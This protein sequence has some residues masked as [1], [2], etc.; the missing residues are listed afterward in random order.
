MYYENNWSWH[1][2]PMEL[3]LGVY[4]TPSYLNEKVKSVLEIVDFVELGIPTDNPKYD[5][6]FI[7]KLHKE[8]SVKGLRAFQY[9]Y[10]IK[11]EKPLIVMAYMEDYLSNLKEL[12]AESSKI[13]AI[14]VLLPDL[15]FEYIEY[16]DDYVKL[17]KEFHM[18]PTFFISSKVPHKLITKLTA[19]NPL[20]VY[21][22]LYATT[23]IKLPVH[24]EKNI[25]IVRQLI[26]K[27]HLIVGFAIDSSE[28]VKII[29]KAGA[30]GIVVGTA[31]LQAINKSIESGLRFLESLK[32]V[33]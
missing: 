17:M 24:I 25:S 13:G 3:K 32:E 10:N 27:Q 30:D 12:F 4:L 23:G 31:F 26:G 21:L 16:L 9:C 1:V 29:F 28:T 5:G 19:Y 18:E 33:M 15:L 22:G 6:P 14:S 2:P 8:S 11:F 20:F 7:R